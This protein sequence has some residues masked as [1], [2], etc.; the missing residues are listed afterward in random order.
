MATVYPQCTYFLSLQPT[1]VFITLHNYQL[2]G[3]HI[4]QQHLHP[5]ILKGLLCGIV[6]LKIQHMGKKKRHVINVIRISHVCVDL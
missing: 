4:L 6:L 3:L 1:I 5:S 2:S